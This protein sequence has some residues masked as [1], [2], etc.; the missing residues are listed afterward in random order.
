MG[1]VCCIPY[2]PGEQLRLHLGLREMM[3]GAGLIGFAIVRGPSWRWQ[4]RLL[5]PCREGFVTIPPCTAVG[6][7]IAYASLPTDPRH[8]EVN[9]HCIVYRLTGVK[10]GDLIEVVEIWEK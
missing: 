2:Y 9:D 6:V 8:E 10:I 5:E 3:N 4:L 7:E 1:S